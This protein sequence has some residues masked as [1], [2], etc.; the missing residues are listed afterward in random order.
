[1]P[2]YLC[3]KKILKKKF[4]VSL[5]KDFIFRYHIYFSASFAFYFLVSYSI[6]ALCIEI[7]YKRYKH[8]LQT[9]KLQK[10][11][12]FLFQWLQIITVST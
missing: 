2:M 5:E 4:S 1:M 6:D 7:K 11:L 12:S 10:M 8:F 3:Q 9:K